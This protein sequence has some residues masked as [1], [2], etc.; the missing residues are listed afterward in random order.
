MED[1]ITL[2]FTLQKI[3]LEL[4][5]LEELKGDLPSIV[6]ALTEQQSALS[7]QLSELET[8]FDENYTARERAKLEIEHLTQRVETLKNQLYQV[9]NNKEYDAITKEINKAEETVISLM[10]QT[11][12]N[13]GEKQALTQQIE[14]VKEK[15][16]G[17]SRELS[18]NKEELKEVSKAHED[19]EL[20]LQGE[21]KNIAARIDTDFLAL[22]DRIRKAKDGKAVVPVRRGACG[23]CY[24]TVSPQLNLLLRKNQEIFTCE[25]C[26]RILIAEEIAAAVNK[27]A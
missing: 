6:H 23:G 24:K 2:L 12:T 17:I 20:Q 18:E 21:R 9:R 1:K 4:M 25:N 8:S 22:Y 5:N 27:V 11:E 19:E 13:E 14:T 16:Q 10:Q 7:E 3:D 15:I 26:G